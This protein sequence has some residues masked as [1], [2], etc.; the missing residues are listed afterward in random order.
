MPAGHNFI[1]QPY[2]PLAPTPLDE[3]TPNL[4]Q[5]CSATRAFKKCKFLG[6]LKISG[7]GGQ[8]YEF[9]ELFIAIISERIMTKYKK[10]GKKLVQKT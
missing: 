6:F 3:I 2:A 4:V 10:W 5:G 1:F 9:S 7:G 8:N